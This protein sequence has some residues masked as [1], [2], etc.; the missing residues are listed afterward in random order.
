MTDEIGTAAGTIWSALHAHG[1]MTLKG[2][3]DKTGLKAPMF[4]WAIGWLAR[5]GNIVLAAEKKTYR[6]RLK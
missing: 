2:L 3:K 4:D 1:E 5:E 6:I